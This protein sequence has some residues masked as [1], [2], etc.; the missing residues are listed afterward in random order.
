MRSFFSETFSMIPVNF[1]Y[2]LVALAI[3]VVST[4]V[5]NANPSHIFALLVTAFVVMQMMKRN[6][7]EVV[8]LNQEMD[9]RNQLLGTPEFFY[10]DANIINLFFNIFAWREFNPNNFDLAIIAVNNVLRVEI[11]SEKGLQRGVDNYEVAVD[12]SND[13][14]NLIHGFI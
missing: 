14:L 5:L 3:L 12:Y 6:T 9:Y 8:D 11:D 2:V 13:A 7:T 1:T 10:L 4:K